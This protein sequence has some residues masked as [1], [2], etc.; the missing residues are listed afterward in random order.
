MP[1]RASS[2]P[3]PPA[4]ASS[5]SRR[6]FRSLLSRSFLPPRFLC[7]KATRQWTVRDRYKCGS[8]GKVSGAVGQRGGVHMMLSAKRDAQK[9]TLFLAALSSA[10]VAADP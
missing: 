6:S 5:A 8:R 4:A 3:L 9:H 1:A 2:P 7:G 10:S